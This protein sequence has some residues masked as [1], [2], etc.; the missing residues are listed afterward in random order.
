MLGNIIN[1][2]NEVVDEVELIYDIQYQT[3]T[4]QFA[5]KCAGVYATCSIEVS[6]KLGVCVY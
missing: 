2:L 4:H 6:N 1:T 5:D 3:F